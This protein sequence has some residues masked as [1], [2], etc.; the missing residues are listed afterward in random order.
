[1]RPC[2]HVHACA[3]EEEGR[4]A[5]RIS[6]HILQGTSP[7]RCSQV[8]AQSVR[9][10]TWRVRGAPGVWPHG[11]TCPAPPAWSTRPCT[12]WFVLSGTP[13]A[14]GE[15]G[16]LGGRR[17]VFSSGRTRLRTGSGSACGRCVCLCAN[18]HVSPSASTPYPQRPPRWS[19]ARARHPTGLEEMDTVNIKLALGFCVRFRSLW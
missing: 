3:Q 15:G 16:M 1:M 17:R 4:G 10:A 12:P 7:L 6:A 8:Q 13:P 14:A 5:W 2:A 19:S 11:R 9:L 18:Q